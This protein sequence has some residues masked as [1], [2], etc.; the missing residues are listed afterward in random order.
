MSGH[1]VKPSGYNQQHFH[2]RHGGSSI[3]LN[4]YA[5]MPTD[6]FRP[7][8]APFFMFEQ[9]IAQYSQRMK[10]IM[11]RNA[12]VEQGKSRPLTYMYKAKQ[13]LRGYIDNNPLRPLYS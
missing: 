5:Q 3:I 10:E 13:A 6:K 8:L 7:N 11:L 2:L 1:G 12:T 9:T 4:Q